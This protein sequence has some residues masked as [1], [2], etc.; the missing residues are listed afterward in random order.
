MLQKKSNSGIKEVKK[1]WKKKRYYFQVYSFCLRFKKADCDN[2]MQ[3][4]KRAFKSTKKKRE[5][6][7]GK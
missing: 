5:S 2:L 4:K 3:K 7:I 6:K 1:W